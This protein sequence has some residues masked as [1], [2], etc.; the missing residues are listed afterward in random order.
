MIY[1]IMILFVFACI[2]SFPEKITKIFT[3]SQII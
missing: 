1:Y 3:P 2:Y